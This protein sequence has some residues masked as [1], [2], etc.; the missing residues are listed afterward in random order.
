MSYEGIAKEKVQNLRI[1]RGIMEIKKQGN[2]VK[3]RRQKLNFFFIDLQAQEER[4]ILYGK[5]RMKNETFYTLNKT[6]QVKLRDI[7]EPI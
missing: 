2:L 7:W 6:S 3:G 4:R 1:G 5:S